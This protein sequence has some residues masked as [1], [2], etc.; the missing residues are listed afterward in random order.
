MSNIEQH[1]QALFCNDSQSI[2]DYQKNMNTAVQ[3]VSDWLQNDKMYTGGLRGGAQTR[4]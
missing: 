4:S 1:R 3:A 2:A